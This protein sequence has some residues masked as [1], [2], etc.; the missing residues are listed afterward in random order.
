MLTEIS[1]ASCENPLTL[2]LDVSCIMERPGTDEADLAEVSQAN[3]GEQRGVERQSEHDPKKPVSR[4]NTNVIGVVFNFVHRLE[5]SLMRNGRRLA[6]L[7]LILE[8]L[9]AALQIS[10]LAKRADLVLCRGSFL[11]SVCLPHGS[12]LE[13]L[14][15]LE[16]LLSGAFAYLAVNLPNRDAS[17]V[18]LA[19]LLVWASEASLAFG[20][21]M[22]KEPSIPDQLAVPSYRIG[23][24]LGRVFGCFAFFSVY[25][26]VGLRLSAMRTVTVRA[27]VHVLDG[28]SAIL[29]S[30]P[31]WCLHPLQNFLGTS[32]PRWFST[33]GLVLEVMSVVAT[34]V[35]VVYLMHP[36]FLVALKIAH[37]ARD[38]REKGLARQAEE[39]Q[40][41]YRCVRE[42][43][44]SGLLLALTCWARVVASPV[45][46]RSRVNFAWLVVV[47][48][49]AVTSLCALSL[50]GAFS[51]GLGARRRNHAAAMRRE[52]KWK[53]TSLIWREH[54][55]H[56]DSAWHS[57]VN[58][59]GERG[60]TLAALLEFY[61]SL[62]DMMPH[63]NSSIH[64]TADVVRQAIIPRSASQRCAMSTIMNEGRPTRPHK[65]VTH[66]W[67]NRFRDL[68]AAIVADALDEAEYVRFAHLLDVDIG[69]IETW[70]RDAGCMELVYWVCAFS[71]NQHCTIC[72]ANP[73]AVKD[74]VSGLLYPLCN[75][76]LRKVWNTTEP[77]NS[78]GESIECEVNKFDDMMR[79][80]SA[81]DQRFAQIVAIDSGFSLFS[82]AW[83]V[84]E[85]AAAGEAG[86][87]QQL[88][89]M[90]MECFDSHEVS[91]HNLQVQSMQASRPEDKDAILRRIP[92]HDCFNRSL[93]DLLF[94]DLLPD[95]SRI[96]GEHQLRRVGALSRWQ[97]VA[98][99]RS[100]NHIWLSDTE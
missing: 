80:L 1:P 95:W 71:V 55:E 88:K 5:A 47:V 22:F 64:T 84:A 83:C 16:L 62:A 73:C 28:V 10:C 27:R 72:D 78:E 51:G 59:L 24:I 61:R 3:E 39:C 19:L 79:S 99:R 93:H 4:C 31:F 96:D 36:F 26:V 94:N 66:N 52:E 34:L 100:S 85:I 37:M 14:T 57:K 23:Q 48:S 40:N 86:M 32:S 87:L 20:K 8:A 92:D 38:L 70:L 53:N 9:L 58:E 30:S 77:T 76:G 97:D 11:G 74:S 54:E 81:S 60:F 25:Y 12:V 45:A 82:R 90:S 98:S 43:V 15:P 7:A 46:Q 69:S 33:T 6:P 89:V 49:Q 44:C 56:V 41:A 35:F 63:W 29:I 18:A 67:S 42:I 75:C 65:M 91:L 17:R 21:V 68:V 13:G 2:K 50:V